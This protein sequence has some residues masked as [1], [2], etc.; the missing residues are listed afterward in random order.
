MITAP[1]AFTDQIESGNRNYQM[2]V[3]CTLTSGTVLTFRNDRVW[4]DGYSYDDALS[5]DPDVLEVGTAIINKLT[6]VVNNMDE[7][8]SSYDFGDAVLQI[9]IGLRED[10]ESEISYI[11]KGIFTVSDASYDT[12]LITLTALDNMWKFDTLYSTIPQVPSTAL[13]IVQDAC[14]V[15]GVTL[16][17]QTFDGASTPITVAPT[18]DTTYR[19]MLAWIG[20][21]VGCDWRV[22]ASGE[23]VPLWY[24]L[25]ALGQFYDGGTFAYNDGD[26]LNGGTFAYNDGD[27]VDS[28]DGGEF[29]WS[30]YFVIHSLATA[31]VAIDDTIITGITLRVENQPVEPEPEPEPEEGEEESPAVTDTEPAEAFTDF[32]TGT[33]DFLILI[34]GNPLITVDNAQSILS[35]LAS[36]LIGM[37]Y[38][39]GQLMHLSD[40]RLEAG[41]VF[42]YA[43]HKGHAYPMICSQTLF[44]LG[45]YQTTTSASANPLRKAAERY[46]AQAQTTVQIHKSVFRERTLREQAEA[47]LQDQ[48]DSAS[49]LYMTTESD[50]SGGTIY[51][52]HD[53]PT[54]A[55]SNI[56]WKMS[57]SAVGVST[58]GGQSY[59]AGLTADGTAIVQRLYSNTITAGILQ[60]PDYAY[61][62]GNFSSAGMLV[63]L[64]NNVIRT[65]S[66]AVVG[67][68]AYISTSLTLG[69]T[70][71]QNG[72][73]TV[74][75]ASGNTI[76]TWDNDGINATN[77]TLNNANV[78]GSVTAT[79]GN[80]KLILNAG[81]L[82]GYYSNNLVGGLSIAR[83]TYDLTSIIQQLDPS[84]QQQFPVT[85][86]T[87]SV[88]KLA[89]SNSV[90]FVTG[91]V[92]EIDF[93][94]NN[95]NCGIIIRDVRE[96]FHLALTN[97][98]IDVARWTVP[99]LTFKGNSVFTDSIRI[100]RLTS[101]GSS[102]DTN[103][104]QIQFCNA[105]AS[106]NIAL[107]FTDYDSVQ[108]PASLTLA[109]N[110]GGEYFIAPNIKATGSV[111]FGGSLVFQ[112]S[113]GNK[114]FSFN[115]EGTLTTAYNLIIPNASYLY[116]KNTSGTARNLVGINSSNDYF[117]GYGSYSNNEGTTYFDGNVVYI[118]SKGNITIGESNGK[119]LTHGYNYGAAPP[120]VSNTGSTTRVSHMAGH[121]S[122]LSVMVY[123]DT[124]TWTNKT[125]NFS[126]S[127]IRLKENIKDPDLD[128]LPV[129]NSIQMHS[130]DW[131]DAHEY[132][133]QP[134]GMVADELEEIDPRFAVGGGYDEEGL[135]NEKSV[136][137]FYL[138]GYLVKA[139]Q[140]LSA[141]I[142][143]LKKG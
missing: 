132:T 127:D 79:S 121:A 78:S 106:Q 17:V 30:G 102:F 96:Y 56:L 81:T 14:T 54:K 3:T 36:R 126:S 74:K 141:E 15:C 10:E 143:S 35:V 66:F 124:A 91:E 44:T 117:F 41:D 120:I 70:N 135:I 110:Q 131:K 140:E 139:V 57:A 38:R 60:S 105:N 114:T 7:A 118:R 100:Q 112:G 123:P 98:D 32:T 116:G 85:S 64:A 18:K 53:R 134:L 48:I 24:N 58:N 73:L 9:Q 88:L 136:D 4:S 113:Q 51:I 130:F 28:V 21:I 122:Y 39:K 89:T 69:G 65:P 129:I 84:I 93:T 1:Q 29:D 26:T 137:T 67:G 133:H 40:P 5:T 82:N 68:N 108:A 76:G 75:D 101:N 87:A 42:V 138:V 59:N 46:S 90:G 99:S 11:T 20:Q 27:D 71:N 52:L 72:T 142:E 62:S 16:G 50:G 23:L 128:A 107:V 125:I 55:E 119:V 86:V 63:D 13:A 92:G 6:L 47:D 77:A 45:D 43:D 103:N 8:Y 83:S 34:E 61:T 33:A 80:N 49:G 22:N 115:S 111:Y 37:R 25:P 12:S 19:Q 94:T 109:G 31:S 95:G 2:L 97:V 104:P